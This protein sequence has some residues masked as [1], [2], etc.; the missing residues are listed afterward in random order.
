[1]FL[2]TALTFLYQSTSLRTNIRTRNPRIRDMLSNKH[3]DNFLAM[4]ILFLCLSISTTDYIT[5]AATKQENYSHTT[6]HGFC[7]QATVQI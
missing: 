7:T 4:E 5:P 6:V 2:S 1:M 3:V